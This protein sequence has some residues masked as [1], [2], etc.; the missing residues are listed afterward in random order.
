MECALLGILEF[1]RSKFSPKSNQ[2]L[3]HPDTPGWTCELATKT[4]VAYIP[5]SVSSK[6][7]RDISCYEVPVMTSNDTAVKRFDVKYAIV[8]PGTPVMGV[9]VKDI[10]TLAI[11]LYTAF[12]RRHSYNDKATW[13]TF[14]E[15][16]T[17]DT[18]ESI[19]KVLKVTVKYEL[20]ADN[21]ELVFVD[22][23]GSRIDQGNPEFVEV[24]WPD[25][26]S[27]VVSNRFGERTVVDRLHY[28]VDSYAEAMK[29]SP[30][31]YDRVERWGVDYG[32]DPYP[33]LKLL[34]GRI[35][36]RLSRLEK[37]KVK[38]KVQVTNG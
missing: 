7:L 30:E 20:T 4:R 28:S 29:N 14:C 22:E 36:Q 19:C 26:D 32:L 18:L 1:V 31:W 13:E 24:K 23:N 5:P 3:V 6:P 2:W 38:E 17:D 27:I 21:Q 25:D 8:F 11:Y 15:E 10:E 12:C 9:G 35:Q 34:W 16:I 37:D 33:I